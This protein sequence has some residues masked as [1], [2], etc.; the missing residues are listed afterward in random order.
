MVV[1]KLYCD[2]KACTMQYLGTGREEHLTDLR[3]AA[4]EVGW[5]SASRSGAIRDGCAAHP[6]GRRKHQN[7]AVVVAGVGH[8]G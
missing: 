5:T 6:I 8:A 7:G 3:K 1:R 4:S 2:H